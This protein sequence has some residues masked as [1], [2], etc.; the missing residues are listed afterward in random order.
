MDLNRR[1][2][3]GSG[4]A[5]GAL[6]GIGFAPAFAGEKKPGWHAGYQTGPAGGFDPNP[7]RL[8]QGKVPP[9]LKGTLYRNGP[10]QFHYGDTYASHWFDGD[11]FIQR[12]HIEDGTATHSGRFVQTPKRVA[13][14]KA[15]RYLADGFGTAGDPNYPVQSSDDVNSANTSVLMAGG[16]LLA[17]WEAGSPFRMDPETLDT[18]GAKVWRDD[19]K[20]MPYLAH[21]KVEPDGRIWNLGVGGPNVAI[22]LS[23]ASGELIEF[24]MTNIGASS[25]IH[26]WAMTENYL[27]ILVQP[28]INT[29]NRPPFIDGFEWRP[30]EG[31]KVLI[32]DKSDFSRTRWSQAPARAF[33]HTGAAWEER[34]GTIKL[35]VAFYDE[36]VLGSGGGADQIRGTW[37]PSKDGLF[38][39]KFT[40]MVIPPKGD[41]TLIETS[42]DGDF[43]VVDPRR[44]GLKRRLSALVTGTSQTHPGATT[45]SLHDWETG[46]T[47]QF[48]FGEGCMIEEFLF[49]PKPGQ[50]SEQESW[51]VGP[52]LNAATGRREVHVFDAAMV[53]DG[54]ICSWDCQY[55]WPLGFHGTWA[56]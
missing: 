39:S 11:G 33:F 41:T 1:H 54:P 36:P 16:E 56:S 23:S 35:D 31:M 32:V 55:T 18:K 27:V 47:E 9:G 13:E 10:G 40:L 46:T 26:D 19:L 8:V 42:L 3:I 7:M 44:H 48:Y 6:S 51:L 34:D 43:P 4:M 53:S 5:L 21:P 12:I 29:R 24:G 38:Q 17:L 2:F 14:Q 49:V 28:W 37:S 25:Y 20:G 50:T 22:Y 15:G 30:E 52:V 45:L